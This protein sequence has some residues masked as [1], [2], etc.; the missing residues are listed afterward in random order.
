M[1]IKNSTSWV[2]NR[3]GNMK[4]TLHQCSRVSSEHKNIQNTWKTALPYQ[5]KKHT[6]S[7]STNFSSLFTNWYVKLISHSPVWI[8]QFLPKQCVSKNTVSSIFLHRK[9]P[10]NTRKC[11]IISK[12]I[13][14]GH[15]VIF[16]PETPYHDDQHRSYWRQ[17]G[18]RAT[19]TTLSPGSV[20]PSM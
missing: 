7:H 13:L 11:A 16:L 12:P 8:F 3:N 19:L 2:D 20:A 4:F 17:V 18:N 14:A 1:S 9:K 6:N 10:H 5:Y 15:R